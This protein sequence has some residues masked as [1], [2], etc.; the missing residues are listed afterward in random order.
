MKTLFASLLLFLALSLAGYSQTRLPRSSYNPVKVIDGV[1]IRDTDNDGWDD[2]WLLL[3]EWPTGGG[4]RSNIVNEPNA[5]YDGDGVSNIKEMLAGTDPWPVPERRQLS[6]QERAAAE[7]AALVRAE[8][9]AKRKAELAEKYASGRQTAAKAA[10]EGG[11]NGDWLSSDTQKSTL[12]ALSGRIRAVQRN[13]R[14]QIIRNMPASPLK[15]AVMSRKVRPSRIR[16]DGTLVFVGSDNLT[17]ADSISTD[18]L[19]PGGTATAIP[20]LSGIGRVVGIWEVEGVPQP[21]HVEFGGRAL[22]IDPEAQFITQHATAVGGT[23]AAAGTNGLARGSAFAATLATSDSDDDYAEMAEAAEDGLQLSNH[24][25]SN[26]TGWTFN[27]DLNN[28]QWVWAGANVAGE[29]A[30]FGFYDVESRQADIIVYSANTYLPVWSAGNDSGEGGPEA[31]EGFWQDTGGGNL[32]LPTLTQHPGDGAATFDN[33]PSQACSKNV[34]VVGAAQDLVGGLNG[35]NPPTPQIAAFSSRGPTDDGRIKPD[36]VANGTTV[37]SSHFEA[38]RPL[39]VN[40][41]SFEAANLAVNGN[42]VNPANWTEVGTGDAAVFRVRFANGLNF[43]GLGGHSLGVVGQGYRVWQDL[44]GVTL[45]PNRVY[46]VSVRIGR[47]NF[48]TTAS[49]SYIVRIFTNG[50]ANQVRVQTFAATNLGL[51]T[52]TTQTFQILTGAVVPPG[53]VRIV[54][55]HGGPNFLPAPN[56]T[57]ANFCWFDAVAFGVDQA[58]IPTNAY[59]DGSLLGRERMDGTSFAAPSVTGSL[60]LLQQLR[61]SSGLPALW[62]SSWKALVLNTAT[63]AGNVGPDFTFG[64]GVMNTLRAA[65]ALQRTNNSESGRLH[66][67][68]GVLFNGGQIEYRFKAVGGEPLKIILTH[69]D[70]AYQNVSIAAP[71]AGIPA[72]TTPDPTTASLI[73]DLDLRVIPPGGQVLGPYVFPLTNNMVNP[74]SVATAPAVGNDDDRNNVEQIIIPQASVVAGGIYTVRISPEGAIRSARVLANGDIELVNS[75]PAAPTSQRFSLAVTGN[76][77]LPED[78]FR[79]TDFDKNPTEHLIEWNSIKGIRY[80]A[81]KSEDLQSWT[82]IL[83]EVT[84]TGISTILTVPVSGTQPAKLF[85]RIREVGL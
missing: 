12:N 65:E 11:I 38:F 16:S 14:E 43:S 19:W 71:D 37:L 72:V 57:Q 41:F 40:N 4:K 28:S 51:D 34:L 78:N 59:T 56:Q 84:A 3:H 15:N 46:R 36:L 76:A 69:T 61:A 30:H 25:Y 31:G 73:N 20:D 85:Y 5:D 68:Q 32:T 82:P 13:Q 47:H 24:S 79:I 18:D 7:S 2:I 17:A 22:V 29:D 55:E 81:E 44:P 67:R 50:F 64:W 77:P 54:L 74:N 83:S 66:I 75:T 9:A 60:A 49:T 63:D 53:D 23:I 10:Q 39:L 48:L 70:P 45:L 1:T 21:A 58:V 62:A 27:P 33:L 42:S 8:D 35:A 6:P 26:R 52:F 80:R